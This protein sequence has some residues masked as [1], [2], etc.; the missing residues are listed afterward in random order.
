MEKKKATNN[1]LAQEKLRIFYESQGGG[2]KEKYKIPEN[3]LQQDV[4]IKPDSEVI[5]VGP[6]G[7]KRNEK[8]DYFVPNLH[9]GLFRIHAFLHE[10]GIKS[11][12]LNCDIDNMEKALKMIAKY[13]P[14]FVAFSPYYD[15]MHNDLKNITHTLESSPNSVVVIGGFEA[16]LNPQWRNLG[17][18][19]DI[20]VR[21][22]G[23]IP[24]LN[25][26]QKYKKFSISKKNIDK[27]KFLDSLKNNFK[28]RDI[29]AISVLEVGRTTQLAPLKERINEELYQEINLNAFQKHLELSPIEKYWQLSRVIFGGKKDSYFRF[30][31]SDHCPYKCIFCQSSIHHSTIIGKNS[32]PVR[33]V[34]PENTIK[35]IK[36]VSDKYPFMGIYID[37][38]NFLINRS[39]A[40]QTLEMIIKSKESGEIQKDLIFQC[41]TRTDNVDLE[42]CNLLKQAGFKTVSLGSESYSMRELEYMK[43]RTSPEQNLKA[44]KMLIKSR[45]GVAEDYLLYV[46]NTTVDTFYE[47]VVGIHHNIG[48]LGVDGSVNLFLSPL[49]STELWGDGYFEKVQEFPYK[50]LFKNNVMF[51]NPKNGYEY[52]GKEIKIPRANIV[53]PHP[54][55]VLVKDP[56]M[57]K[58]SLNSLQYLPKTVENLRAISKGVNMSRSFVTLCH[59]SAASIV[60]YELTNEPRWYELEKEIEKTV[61]KLNKK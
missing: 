28:M 26:V 41:R 15:T 19:V 55:L 36:A 57:R 34:T 59:L 42:I 14:P 30:I 11:V 45:L 32:S 20:L 29:P 3:L 8:D 47:N 17:G 39:R 12:M 54:E 10:H 50:E 33:Y 56:L 61:I 43:K 52:I 49:P 2:I 13:H 23:E 22:E 60:L 48:K 31:T 44:V 40:M 6:D 21:G 16:S 35:I 46:P 5:L 9:N 7:G 24:L 51:R 4:E 27:K 25:I 58:V 53:L 1:N 38:D 18:L 37:D